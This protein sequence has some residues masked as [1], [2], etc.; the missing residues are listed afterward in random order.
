MPSKKRRAVSPSP[1]Q[2]ID[3][4]EPAALDPLTPPEGAPVERPVEVMS[5]QEARP[6]VASLQTV[7]IRE[8]ADSPFLPAGRLPDAYQLSEIIQRLGGI[9]AICTEGAAQVVGELSSQVREFLLLVVSV[10]LQ[11]VIEPPTVR[12]TSR[13]LEL[14]TG[15][16]R[17][18]A[19]M[20]AGHSVVAVR[21]LEGVEDQ[22]A[23]TVVAQSNQTHVELT[24]WQRLRLVLTIRAMLVQHSKNESAAKRGRGR[25][26]REDGASRVAPLLGMPYSTAKAYVAMSE[27][28][29]DGVLAQVGDE[30][31]VTHA[32]MARLP[33]KQLHDLSKIE[34]ESERIVAIRRAI[35]SEKKVSHREPAKPTTAS[36]AMERSDDGYTL[37]VPR[38]DTL[39]E[40]NARE[41][42][43]ILEEEKSKVVEYVQ[44]LRLAETEAELERKARLKAA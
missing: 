30:L 34:S 15:H 40:S 5:Q 2:T 8:L 44:Q 4:T 11:G 1:A 37:R 9:S 19:A 35:G 36:F 27:A 39:D 32:S 16:R 12:R 7:A 43:R 33:C 38:L 41:L 18:L 6:T 26:P 25:P 10:H 14:V 24:A 20:M 23:A 22:A 3:P 21:L 17:V 31:T 28:L 29:S 13:G 42:L